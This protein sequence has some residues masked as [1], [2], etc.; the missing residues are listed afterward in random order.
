[1]LKDTYYYYYVLIYSL[2]NTSEGD[3]YFLSLDGDSLMM[4]LL[5]ETINL[6]RN[7]FLIDP[8]SICLF[9]NKY[10]IE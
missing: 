8:N 4:K 6:Q 7:L 10:K 9:T 3:I 5:K 2:H 1:M